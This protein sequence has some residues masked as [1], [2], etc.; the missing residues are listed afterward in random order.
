MFYLNLESF[1]KRS[2]FDSSINYEYTMKLSKAAIE[3]ISDRK[4]LLQIALSLDFSE[5]WMRRVIENNKDNG[6]LTTA[7][8]LRV[9]REETGLTDE[10]ILEEESTEAT[11]KQ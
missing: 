10:Q 1:Y 5:Q 6:P 9:I 3:Q 2:T 11:A 7:M 4:V 8:A